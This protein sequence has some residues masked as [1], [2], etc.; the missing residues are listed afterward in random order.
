MDRTENYGLNKP[1]QDDFYNIEDSNNNMDIVDTELK[2]VEDKADQAFTQ[3]D[4]GKKTIKSAIIGKDP[5][6]EVPTDPTFGD[7]ADAIG[8]IETGISTDDAT[9]TVGDILSGKTAYAKGQK[10]TG[11]IPSKGAQTYTPGTAN[12]TIGAKQYLSG[13]QTILG[14]ANLRPEN[15]LNGI[16]IFGIMGSFAGKRFQTGTATSPFGSR[17]FKEYRHPTQEVTSAYVEYSGLDFKPNLIILVNDTSFVSE[18][19][20]FTAYMSHP[21]IDVEDI[22]I[23]SHFYIGQYSANQTYTYAMANAN[24][25]YVS[26]NGFLL[27]VRKQELNYTFYAF[28]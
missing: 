5:A 2:R 21:Y 22:I 8:Q 14:D 6:I 20:N 1:S 13:A 23:N 24:S 9:A 10:I 15:I 19:N 25:I 16:P 26:D 17:Q 7:L 4:N 27:P 12:Q 28:G 11:D 18:E 3:A